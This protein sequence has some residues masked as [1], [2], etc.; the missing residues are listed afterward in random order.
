MATVSTV[1]IERSG[2]A[3]RAALTQ[4][5][6]QDRARFESE[7]RGALHRAQDDLDLTGVETVLRRWHALATLA[8]NPLSEHELAQIARAWT[9]DNTGLR[10][11]HDDGSWHTL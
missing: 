8:A 11:R 1:I 7:L 4:H 5:A 3:V 6:P 2:P 9:G 10:E